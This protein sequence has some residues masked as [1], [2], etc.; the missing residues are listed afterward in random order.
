MNMTLPISKVVQR[1]K[2]LEDG[3]RIFYDWSDVSGQ[4]LGTKGFWLYNGRGVT[5]G[6]LSRA[7]VEGDH[8][9]QL[10]HYS[11]T[12]P[13]K[14][15][16]LSRRLLIARFL[17]RPEWWGFQDHATHD[18]S[19]WPHWAL[20]GSL[21]DA[22]YR[23]FHHT[24]SHKG[25]ALRFREPAMQRLASDF[26]V[27]AE[28]TTNWFV[29]DIDNHE[30]TAASTEIHL[31]L[32]RRL[33]DLMPDLV[34][35]L[36]N[37]AVFYDYRQ[38]SPRGIHI[39]VTLNGLP[40]VTEHLHKTVRTFLSD[41]ADPVLDAVLNRHGLKT[42][43]SIEILPTQRN[44]IRMF[45]SCDRSVFSTTEL[46]SRQGWFD[47]TSLLQHI[48]GT[49]C[50]GDPVYRYSELAKR[51]IGSPCHEGQSTVIVDA[52]VST[53]LA[54]PSR[55]NHYM[56]DLYHAALNG[57]G[58]ADVLFQAYLSPLAR[59]LFFRDFFDEPNRADLV[60]KT[61][62]DW[63]HAKHN[64][65]VSRIRNGKTRNLAAVLKYIMTHMHE[66]PEPIQKFWERVRH[67]D[68]K[69]PRNKISLARCMEIRLQEPFLAT[70]A[71]LTQVHL[72]LEESE[73]GNTYN[74]K[75]KA[76]ASSPPPAASS[77]PPPLPPK[78][79]AALSGHLSKLPRLQ[80]RT[81]TKL[82]N[83]TKGLLHEI[84]LTG[85]RRISWKRLNEL[86]GLGNSRRH[87]ERYKKILYGAGILL[88]WR[89][90]GQ[91]KKKRTLYRL[92]TW[93]IHEM[94]AITY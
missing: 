74:R 94:R 6:E 38:D 89:N 18:I 11:Q 30:P 33:V 82:I 59:A 90:S 15:P 56:T 92:N 36:G 7:I 52:R 72:L 60:T 12:Q 57:V 61:L 86:A 8:A 63:L 49:V 24:N 62:M 54:R 53:L 3:R 93:V 65:R 25:V 37:G 55:S 73:K 27:R 42:M 43:G 2:F 75:D 35:R 26:F 46:T 16:Y 79:H 83:F 39:W 80:E 31:R 14:E 21:R 48:K 41:H 68:K 45:G 58:E 44:L 40:R 5:K 9:A 81:K 87:A 85:Q 29:L 50:N 34:R 22:V 28:E 23:S 67:N 66:T 17:K 47:A 1:R 78:I 64:G 20:Y 88:S 70:K 13:L 51:G 71:F 32:L 19:Q 91:P 69:H 77:S 76:I 4:Q 10:F 84:G